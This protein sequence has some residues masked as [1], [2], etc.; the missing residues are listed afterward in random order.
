MVVYPERAAIGARVVPVHSMR[1]AAMV[2][3]I[4]HTRI[5]PEHARTV[6]ELLFD[7]LSDAELD[8]LAELIHKV[9]G[10]LEGE[11]PTHG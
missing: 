3:C 5:S 11:H 4:S 6:R 2:A 9:L 10:R 1:Q 7:W 8:V